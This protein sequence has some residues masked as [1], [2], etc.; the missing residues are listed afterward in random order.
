MIRRPPR[1]TRTDTLFPYTTLF[2]SMVLEVMGR[3]AGHIAIHA[4]VAGGADICLIPELP[5]SLD[6][7]TRKLREV[8]ASGRAFALVVVAEAVRTVDGQ[9]IGHRSADGLVR[10]GGIGQWLAERIETLLGADS[11]RSEEHT[12][13]LQS[14]MR[15]SYAVFCLKKKNKQDI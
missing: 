1:S 15:I 11:R 10:Y 3:D 14:L 9:P 8:K 13:E 2:R 6:G 4:A 7:V 12:S 5:Y